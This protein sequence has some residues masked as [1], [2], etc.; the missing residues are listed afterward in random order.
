LKTES[1]A[2]KSL[3]EDPANARKHSTKNLEAI[4]GSLARFGQQKP[5]VVGKNNVVIAGNGTLAAARAL[6]WSDINVVRTKLEGPE[7][8]AFALADNRAGELAEWDAGV[9]GE[10]LKALKEMDFDLDSIGFDDVDLDKMLPT[11]APTEGLTDPD[12]VPEQVETRCKPGDLWLLGNHRLLCGDS[13][14]VRHVERLMGGEKAQTFFIDPPYGDNVGGLRTKSAAE[15]VPG[16]GLI[17]RE[18]FIANDK[19]IDWLKDVFNLVPTFLE[20]PSTKMVFFKWDKYVEIL[21][22]AAAFGKPSALCVWDRVR[23]ANN[24]FRFQPQHELCLHW[25][26]Q[27]DKKESM[28]LSNVWHEPKELENKEIHP[29]VKPIAILEPAIRV[30]TAQGKSVLDLFLGSGSTLIA[31]EKTGRKCYGM[32]LDARYCDVI[33]A[34]WEQFTGKTAKLSDQRA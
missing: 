1:V 19:E 13:T 32:E 23:R 27:E 2:I 5:I 20:E 11:V 4:K 10:T 29:T 30:T 14:N 16:K 7:A 3:V 34:R 9:L 15:R 6:G 28:S 21:E 8:I 33:I 18:T 12:S 24:F 31:C 25:G 22:M 26:S 17:K